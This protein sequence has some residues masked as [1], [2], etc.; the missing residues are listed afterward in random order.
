[1]PHIKVIDFDGTE[2]ELDAP[3]NVSLMQ[4][5]TSAGI[6]GIVAECGGC[7]LCA[8][9]HVYVDPAWLPKLDEPAG[10][11]EDM[12]DFTA[13][14]CRENSRLSCQITLTEELDGLVVRLPETQ[15]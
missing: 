11:E 14:E 5:A 4:A 15:T 13:S 1:M 10:N 7:A 2:H 6:D 8:T 9:C 12:L 3:T